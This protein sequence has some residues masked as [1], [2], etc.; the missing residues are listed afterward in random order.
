M[1]VGAPLED[2]KRKMVVLND[3]PVDLWAAANIV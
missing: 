1:E 3:F 2:F